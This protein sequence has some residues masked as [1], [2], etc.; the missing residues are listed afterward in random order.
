MD[1]LSLFT[2]LVFSFTHNIQFFAF[3]LKNVNGKHYNINNE[4]NSSIKITS[5]YSSQQPYEISTFTLHFIDGITTSNG[6]S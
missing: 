4:C 3:L 5:F 1:F 2:S 6:Q